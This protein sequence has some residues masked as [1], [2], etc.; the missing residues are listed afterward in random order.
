MSQRLDLSSRSRLQ[1]REWATSVEWIPRAFFFPFRQNIPLAFGRGRE[2]K[3]VVIVK[4]WRNIFYAKSFSRAPDGVRRERKK[5]FA[6]PA[7]GD[8]Q[9]KPEMT[10]LS[11]VFSPFFREE[12]AFAFIRYKVRFSRTFLVVEDR[13][14]TS[15]TAVLLLH[16]YVLVSLESERLNFVDKLENY[17][18]C[19][20][21]VA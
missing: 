9:K 4:K 16:S 11:V 17:A 13:Q 3:K 20:H 18:E 2:P 7:R 5:V 1:S 15:H 10:I 14:K 12:R 6:F 21:V 19:K 8:P